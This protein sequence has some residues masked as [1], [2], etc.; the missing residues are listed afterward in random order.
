MTQKEVEYLEENLVRFDWGDNK[1]G[2][3]DCDFCHKYY[4]LIWVDLWQ[5][6]ES[7]EEANWYAC[8]KCALKQL[9]EDEKW[10]KHCEELYENPNLLK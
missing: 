5:P 3:T 7:N 9:E 10:Q 6:A 1:T 2:K 8:T 4:R